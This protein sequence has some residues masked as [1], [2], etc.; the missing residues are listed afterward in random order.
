MASF[1]V[2]PLVIT[3]SHG[4]A[5]V[6]CVEVPLEFRYLGSRSVARVEMVCE[7][8]WWSQWLDEKET[9]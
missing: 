6:K 3:A 4:F 7:L 8:E 5:S 9:V 2:R 1:S